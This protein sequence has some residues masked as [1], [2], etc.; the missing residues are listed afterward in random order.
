MMT[1]YLANVT[2]LKV[3]NED[4]SNPDNNVL[5]IKS[6]PMDNS[7]LIAMPKGI[8]KI[9]TPC[10]KHVWT[11]NISKDTSNAPENW[12]NGPAIPALSMAWSI[13]AALPVIMMAGKNRAA[14]AGG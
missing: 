5:I 14:L 12:L 11:L 6:G 10:N 7:F 8:G 1:L 13:L 9:L 2:F 4:Y 3:N